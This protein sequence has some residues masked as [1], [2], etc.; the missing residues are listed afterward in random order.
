M[1]SLPELSSGRVLIMVEADERAA[2]ALNILNRN[3]AVTGGVRIPSGM[4][5]SE[6]VGENLCGRSLSAA[7]LPASRHSKS[8]FLIPDQTL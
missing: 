3:H 1:S 5:P 2:D 4:I 8:S 7:Y 6:D